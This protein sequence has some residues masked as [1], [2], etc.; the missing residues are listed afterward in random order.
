M[1]HR[2]IAED[3]PNGATHWSS[4]HGYPWLKLKGEEWYFYSKHRW[5]VFTVHPS[6]LQ[7][8]KKLSQDW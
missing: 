6:D 1:T 5:Q 2:Y 8:L 3:R 4:E 7:Y